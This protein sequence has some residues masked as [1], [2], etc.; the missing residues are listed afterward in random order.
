MSAS[1]QIHADLCIDWACNMREES[2]NLSE[3]IKVRDSCKQETES[4]N[5]Q[6][7]RFMLTSNRF[8]RANECGLLYLFIQC[9]RSFSAAA[10]SS[11]S[12]TK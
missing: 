9:T 11:V 7:G 10:P 5:Q 1:L 4:K 2:E 12:L 6:L 8:A 3:L